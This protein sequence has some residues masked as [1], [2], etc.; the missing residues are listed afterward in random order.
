[1]S[2][3]RRAMVEEGDG[4]IVMIMMSIGVGG[5]IRL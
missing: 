5:S 3:V 2:E 4:G 1:M